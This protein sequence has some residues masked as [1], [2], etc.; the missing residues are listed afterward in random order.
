MYSW[1]NGYSNYTLLFYLA[2]LFFFTINDAI[3]NGEKDCVVEECN[4]TGRSLRVGPDRNLTS[5]WP[6]GGGA[7]GGERGACRG[8]GTYTHAHIHTH[9]TPHHTHTARPATNKLTR[10]KIHI[11]LGRRKERRR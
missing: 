9:D 11:V 6:C 1:E 4:L 7:S 3:V 10:G 8:R 5:S 2:S